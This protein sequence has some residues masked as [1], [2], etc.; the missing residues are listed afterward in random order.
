MAEH[1]ESLTFIGTIFAGVSGLVAG[2]G[3]ALHS[4]GVQR[5][6][7][8][9]KARIDD[10]DKADVE[11]RD[12]GRRFEDRILAEMREGRQAA[13]QRALQR[14]QKYD[15]LFSELFKKV[16]DARIDIAELKAA[17]KPGGHG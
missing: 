2:I 15:H 4:R 17:T 8:A 6:L 14:D 3:A 12:N 5:E 7:G 10:A 16:E 11:R 13:E 9:V 1:T